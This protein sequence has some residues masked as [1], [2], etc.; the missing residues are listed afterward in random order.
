MIQSAIVYALCSKLA[1][2]QK[3]YTR[4]ESAPDRR[5]MVAVLWVRVQIV[6]MPAEQALS[7]ARPRPNELLLN[8]MEL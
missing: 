7:V 1:P 8:T 3:G 2:S 6:N 5:G 4:I